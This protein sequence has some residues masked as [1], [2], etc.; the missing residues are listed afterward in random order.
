MTKPFKIEVTSGSRDYKIGDFLNTIDE[1]V[2][3]YREIDFYYIPTEY[4]DALK[5]Y[6]QYL[7]GE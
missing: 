1:V 7:T 3:Y 6:A 2:A 4:A 5:M